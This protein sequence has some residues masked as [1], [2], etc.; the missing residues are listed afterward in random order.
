[1]SLIAPASAVSTAAGTGASGS[2]EPVVAGSIT[3]A[4]RSAVTLRCNRFGRICSSF[5]KARETFSVMS[6]MPVEPVR[7]KVDRDCDGNRLVVG[8]QRGAV[9]RPYS[10]APRNAKAARPAAGRAAFRF[11]AD[12][13]LEGLAQH[14]RDQLQRHRDER[15]PDEQR[16]SQRITG[17]VPLADPFQGINSRTHVSSSPFDCDTTDV[18]VAK[19]I[20][21][22]N[23][24]TGR[25]HCDRTR[26]RPD[27]S[28]A[29]PG[30]GFRNPGA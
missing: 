5:A 26:G 10:M 22:H 16:R 25:R 27:P 2:R 12:D 19:V 1:M 30:A 6:A 28:D 4:L 20:L 23:E 18:S 15:R 29:A 17:Q 7:G 3:V 13:S 8:E 24:T 11:D 9:I 21:L 14:R